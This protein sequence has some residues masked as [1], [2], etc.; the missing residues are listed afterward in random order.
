MFLARVA[1][2]LHAAAG[3]TARAPGAD[4]EVCQISGRLLGAVLDV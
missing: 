3:L 2:L 4:F 1:N